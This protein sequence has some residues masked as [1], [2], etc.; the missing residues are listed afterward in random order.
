MSVVFDEVL[1]EVTPPAGGAEQGQSPAR[2]PAPITEQPAVLRALDR[3]AR[4]EAWLRA[5]T[6]AT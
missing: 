6:R 3:R 2:E 4:R 5:R 1:A